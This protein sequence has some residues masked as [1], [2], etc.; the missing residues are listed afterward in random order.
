MAYLTIQ[1]IKSYL[2]SENV[3]VITRNDDTLV[4]AAIDTAISEAK[5]YLSA[6]NREAIFGETGSNRNELLLTM[7][8]DCASWHI[9]KLSNAGI[10]YEYRKQIYDRA[11]KW[12]EDV[13]KSR[14]KPDLP[15]LENDEGISNAAPIR[16]GS[17]A[18]KSQR[19]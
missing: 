8:K 1:E 2:K 4:T 16:F 6:F 10:N 5:G 9:M 3:D 17:N 18:K 19:F 14:I 15:E 11:I 7:V 12:F 13:Q